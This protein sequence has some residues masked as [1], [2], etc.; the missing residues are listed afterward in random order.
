MIYTE[1]FRSYDVGVHLIDLKPARMPREANTSS[2]DS[3]R[4]HDF[5]VRNSDARR[6]Q[7]FNDQ[8]AECLNLLLA[9]RAIHNEAY[10]VFLKETNFVTAHCTSCWSESKDQAEKAGY[11]GDRKRAGYVGDR[12][13]PPIR[14]LSFNTI[15][16]CQEAAIDRLPDLISSSSNADSAFPRLDKLTLTQYRTPNPGPGDWKC[17][18]QSAIEKAMRLAKEV[19]FGVLPSGFTNT[20]S[21]RICV[22]TA[23]Q[24]GK[25]DRCK[26]YVSGMLGKDIQ[27]VVIQLVEMKLFS[28]K[29]EVF[30]QKT[31][32]RMGAMRF[33]EASELR[34]IKW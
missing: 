16:F 9:S 27:D 15:H 29:I 18:T 20:S 33:V 5:G 22:V 32:P 11:F 13:L 12:R 14:K 26:L 28:R 3:R 31:Y 4:N 25:K 6:N 17:W 7:A 34:C 8:S 30:V 23:V 21:P 24:S 10:P 19:Q 1:L 2:I